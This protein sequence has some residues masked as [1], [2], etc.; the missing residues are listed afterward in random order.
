MDIEKGIQ[1]QIRLI[2][3]AAI[4]IK[5]FVMHKRYDQNDF[6][7]YGKYGRYVCLL[8]FQDICARAW[9]CAAI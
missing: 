9:G 5:P 6:A 7:D 8:E 1:V 4:H 2:A 3:T